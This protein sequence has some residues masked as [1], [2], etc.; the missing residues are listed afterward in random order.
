MLDTFTHGLCHY[1]LR[2][3]A[4]PDELWCLADIKLNIKFTHKGYSIVPKGKDIASAFSKQILVRHVQNGCAYVNHM[5]LHGNYHDTNWQWCRCYVQVPRQNSY[6]HVGACFH[7][8]GGKL[9]IWIVEPGYADRAPIRCA[10]VWAASPLY[11]GGWL[12]DLQAQP[13]R[14]VI[15]AILVSWNSAMLMGFYKCVLLT[16]QYYLEAIPW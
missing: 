4:I 13:L 14:V 15:S 12:Y 5:P 8:V 7:E 2:V 10:V 11:W 6:G 3:A 16:W 1:V 9:R